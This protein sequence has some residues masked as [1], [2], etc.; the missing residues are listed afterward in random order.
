MDQDIKKVRPY[1]ANLRKQLDAL[2]PRLEK[3]TAKP[4]DEQ[5]LEQSSERARLETT[6][7]YAYVLNSLFFAYGKVVG[8]SAEEMAKIRTELER[9]QGYMKKAQGQD[10]AAT[11]AAR[12]QGRQQDAIKRELVRSLGGT[13]RDAEPTI[14]KVH[15]QGKHTKFGA[16]DGDND[17]SAQDAAD[18]QAEEPTTEYNSNLVSEITQ[19][20]KESKA[21]G[22]RPQ[23]S[24][25]NKVSK[26]KGGNNNN[27]NKRK[28]K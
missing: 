12:D 1:I 28:R 24:K 3:L 4:L 27:N 14:S 15:F 2:R 8:L 19:R 23:R 25:N 17:K 10:A 6:N 11:K 5:L 21:K 20:I 18:A 9:V 26:P 22:S 7:T 13:D 16:A